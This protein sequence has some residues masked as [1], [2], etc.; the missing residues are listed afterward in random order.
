MVC[1]ECGL[2]HGLIQKAG[3]TGYSNFSLGKKFNIV[4]YFMNFLELIIQ[5]LIYFRV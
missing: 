2:R 3:I 4:V 5:N 1:Y